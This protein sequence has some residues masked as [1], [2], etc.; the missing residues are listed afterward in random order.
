MSQ[1]ESIEHEALRAPEVH[2]TAIQADQ[3]ARLATSSAD[4][5][6]FGISEAK[7]E[8]AEDGMRTNG[9]SGSFEWWYLDTQLTDGSTLTTVLHPKPMRDVSGPLA[10]YVSVVLDRPSGEHVERAIR[11]PAEKF[12]ASRQVCDVN[13]GSNYLRGDLQSY[14]LHVGDEM[15]AL[16]LRLQ[17]TVPSW[18]PATGH[19]V[20]SETNYFAWLSAVPQGT[21]TGALRIDGQETELAGTGYHDHNWGN[22][23]MA[24]LIH[25]WYWGR[26][27]V[28]NY[29]IIAAQLTA[30]EC[31]GGND[32]PIVMVAQENEVLADKGQMTYC[33][34]VDESSAPAITYDYDDGSEIFRISFHGGKKI[35]ERSVRAAGRH[36]V[37]GD[38]YSR[39]SGPVR[40]ERLTDATRFNK[41][42]GTGIWEEMRFG[43]PC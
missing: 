43:S 9:G 14:D 11:V 7:I 33:E 39:F 17:S 28:G 27:R 12:G 22:A 34:V 29:S 19:F 32:M 30:Q 15:L 25:H 18:R 1:F 31:H 8:P 20:F 3:F 24:N 21:I 37:D 23:H 5:A 42:F 2:G 6:H 10:P 16:D 40:L 4:F 38:M 41:L 13:V 36:A 35:A 26:A